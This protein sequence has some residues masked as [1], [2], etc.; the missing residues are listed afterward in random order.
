MPNPYP[1]QLVVGGVVKEAG[2]LTFTDSG[3]QPGSAT[4]AIV[5]GGTSGAN[6]D[7]SNPT[8]AT[9]D[10]DP[11]GLWSVP[12][13]QFTAKVA[14]WYEVKVWGT[15]GP[16]A[17]IPAGG[18]GGANA[19]QVLFAVFGAGDNV[20]YVQNGTVAAGSGFLH[21]VPFGGDVHLAVG[22][23]CAINGDGGTGWV[24]DDASFSIRLIVAG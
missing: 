7:G 24:V 11:D 5:S 9:V 13:Q 4:Y 12:F 16:W 20:Y 14:G 23:G 17:S 18:S 22:D 19:S 1:M 10:Y 2:D 6:W 15:N 21:F 3:N 8:F